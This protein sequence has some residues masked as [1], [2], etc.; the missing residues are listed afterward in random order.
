MVLI[1]ARPLDVAM[2][3]NGTITTRAHLRVP[4]SI[5]GRAAVP[6][7]QSLVTH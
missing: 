3:M 4:I 2:V 5:V 6:L 7:Q 1:P